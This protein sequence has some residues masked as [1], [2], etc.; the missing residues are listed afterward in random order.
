VDDCTSSAFGPEIVEMDG[1]A[2]VDENDETLMQTIDH[3]LLRVRCLQ[4][5]TK[6]TR[7]FSLSTSYQNSTRQKIIDDDDAV[8]AKC[9]LFIG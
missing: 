8:A 1:T 9:L 6:S 3:G 4:M 7:L 2:G 5:C